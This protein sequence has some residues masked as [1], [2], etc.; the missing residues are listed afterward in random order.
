MKKALLILIFLSNFLSFGQDQYT[1]KSG[2]RYVYKNEII[3]PKE[4]RALLANNQRALSLYNEGRNK[5]TFGNILLYGGIAL[6]GTVAI[7]TLESGKDA[8]SG[9]YLL[10]AIPI[11]AIPIK[12]GF[13]NKIR[14]S[15]DLLNQDLKNPKT[16]QM[17]SANIVANANGIG[18]SIT[19]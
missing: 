7:T 10:L 14:K 19:F 11:I 1:F 5:K 9:Q 3:K 17:E 18:F 4:V 15:I 2:G 12:A 16:T 13:S 6:M 8:N